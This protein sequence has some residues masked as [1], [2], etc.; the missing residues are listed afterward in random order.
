MEDLQNE[1]YDKL[2]ELKSLA[3]QGHYYCDDSWYSCPKA[4]GGCADDDQ[5][6]ECN[7]FVEQHNKKVYEL[8]NKIY[9]L[10]K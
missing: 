9:R 3:I 2:D 6:D 8:Y 7:C 4:E 1:V 10:L 5:G